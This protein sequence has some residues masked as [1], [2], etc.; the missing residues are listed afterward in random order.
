MTYDGVNGLEMNV[1][2]SEKY[3]R[4]GEPMYSLGNKEPIA[5]CCL[6]ANSG[7]NTDRPLYF[8][9]NDLEYVSATF[10]RIGTEV[11]FEHVYKGME[12][13]DVEN[14]LDKLRNT[15][16]KECPCFVFY[17]SGHGKECGIQLDAN[18]TFPFLTIVDCIYSLKDLEGKPKVF[19]FD[20]CRV[21]DDKP[22]NHK[23]CK[24]E[25]YTDCVIAY[26]CSRGE[27]AFISNLPGYTENSSIFTKAFCSMLST[28]HCQWPLVSILI[29]ASSLT[30]KTMNGYHYQTRE[31]SEESVSSQTPHVVVKLGK[32]LYLCCE[33][34]YK[35]LWLGTVYAVFFE[36]L[37]FRS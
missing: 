29:H 17:Y 35:V 6:V 10:K 28:N 11:M 37:M 9:S 13:R 27:E 25:S 15:S 31:N 32:Q 1:L 3:A 21:L 23:N 4:G 7:D 19:I 33:L 24:V 2:E 8:I 26:A 20:C 18:T 22:E 34:H 14:L 16:L 12:T 36:G 30:S 5:Y